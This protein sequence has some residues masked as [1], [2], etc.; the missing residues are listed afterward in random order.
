MRKTFFI[1]LAIV[2]SLFIAQ[3]VFAEQSVTFAWDANAEPIDG[4]KILVKKKSVEKYDDVSAMVYV[5]PKNTLPDVN[6][7]KFTVTTGLVGG[8]EYTAV[9]VAYMNLSTGEIMSGYS[10]E[11]SFTTGLSGVVNF[12]VIIIAE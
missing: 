10:N 2:M 6:N 11:V 4:Y 1:T 8:T 9:C 12:R 3:S 7:P 5:I